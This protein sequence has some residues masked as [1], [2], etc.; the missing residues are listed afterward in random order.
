MKI[1][2]RFKHDC[3]DCIF[4][5]WTLEADLY[6]CQSEWHSTLIARYSDK[7]EFYESGIGYAVWLRNRN[8]SHS[9]VSALNLAVK[10]GYLKDPP[11]RKLIIREGFQLCKQR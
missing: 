11:R 9:L 3:T 7:P 4:L 5:G 6:F 10:K 8:E 2:P 1:K